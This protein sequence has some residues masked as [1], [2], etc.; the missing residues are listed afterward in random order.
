MSAYNFGGTGVTSRNFTRDVA[1]GRGDNVDTNFRR[2]AHK[3][4]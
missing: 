2:G 3:N 1:R 4:I